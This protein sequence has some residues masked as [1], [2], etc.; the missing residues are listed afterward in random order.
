MSSLW[1]PEGE[2]RVPMGAA[3]A[4]AGAAGPGDAAAG[5]GAGAA[6]PAAGGSGPGA[7]TGAADL[8]GEAD[9][10][11]AAL[12][13]E[14]LAALER[15]LVGVPAAD[16]V[17]NHCYGLFELAAVHLGQQPPQLGEA[18]VAI[19]ALGAVVERLGDRLGASAPT[20]V[21]ALGQI[22]LAYVQIAAARAPGEGAPR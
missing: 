13:A 15:E 3:E 1:T 10:A 7:G 6:G 18:Q 21:E 8:A 16:V 5:P 4:P 2:R 14:Q 9:E 20:L 17:A 22:R 11:K 12:A 19:D